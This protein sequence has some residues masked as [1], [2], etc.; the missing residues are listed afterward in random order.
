MLLGYLRELLPNIETRP[1][2]RQVSNLD[3]VTRRPGDD[4]LRELQGS[5]GSRDGLLCPGRP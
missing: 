3:E 4:F 2:E 5:A 1:A